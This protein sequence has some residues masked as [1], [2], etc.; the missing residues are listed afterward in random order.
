M[1]EAVVAT[2]KVEAVVVGAIEKALDGSA[3]DAS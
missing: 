1:P 2:Q 3:V